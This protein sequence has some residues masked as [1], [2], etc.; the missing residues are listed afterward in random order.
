MGLCFYVKKL[1]TGMVVS[2]PGSPSE[3]NLKGCEI[4]S[5]AAYNKQHIEIYDNAVKKVRS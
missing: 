4:S 5:E 1:A 3:H 2:L